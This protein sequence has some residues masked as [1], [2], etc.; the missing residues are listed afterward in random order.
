M[1][2]KGRKCIAGA[3]IVVAAVL[4]A[5]NPMRRQ[6][7]SPEPLEEKRDMIMAERQYRGNMNIPPIDASAPVHTETATFALG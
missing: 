3:C 2:I 1:A 7:N 6:S 4:V 5:S